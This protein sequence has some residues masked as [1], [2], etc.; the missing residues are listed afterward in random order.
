VSAAIVLFLAALIYANLP[1]RLT[2]GHITPP[3][4]H[5]KKA[6]LV[7]IEDEHSIDREKAISGESFLSTPSLVVAVRRPLCILCRREAAHISTL[8]PLLNEAGIRLVAVTYQTKGV[9]RFKNDFDGDVYLDTKRTF[10]GPHERWLPHWMGLLRFSL[11]LPLIA[12]I[13]EGLG[14]AHDLRGEGRLLGGV[15]LMDGNELVWSHLER[16]W[17]DKADVEEIKAAIR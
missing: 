15:F 13:R 10:Y 8:K 11:V 6:K 9:N 7:K 12:S 14:R 3:L 5:L 2:I 16:Y 4:S 1:T 17:G